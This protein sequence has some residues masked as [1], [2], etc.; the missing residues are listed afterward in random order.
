MNAGAFVFVDRFDQLGAAVDV[1]MVGRLVEDQQLRAV[2]GGKAHQQAR[3]L[4]ARQRR[5]RRVARD[6]RK[7][8][9]APYGRGF[10]PP[11]PPRMRSATCEVGR[12]VEI[13]IVDLMLGEKADVE[14]ARRATSL[15][16]G[17]A[18]RP[19]I[20]LAKVDLPLP[21]APSRPMRSSFDKRQVELGE[22]D[23]LAIADADLL[24]RDDRRAELA[25]DRRPAERQ[26]GLV[27][28]RGDRLHPAP[29]S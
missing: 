11:A 2:E 29:A 20:S 17:C 8:R 19:P 23:A 10:S 14:L 28:E 15:P 6:R 9:S 18:S 27:D 26:H 22:H 4:A 5:D 21:L 12:A 7:S 1:E 25:G 13:E 16:L 24:H 3:L